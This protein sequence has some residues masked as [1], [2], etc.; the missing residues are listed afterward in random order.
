MLRVQLLLVVCAM[1]S[2]AAW[3]EERRYHDQYGV[4]AARRIHAQEA[5]DNRIT[6][7]MPSSPTDNPYLAGLVITLTDNRT[8]ICGGTLISSRKV[9][10]AGQC[11][12]DGQSQGRV[13]TVVL[14]SSKLFSGG[15]RRVATEIIAHPKFDPF[16]I[17]NDLAMVTI[18]PLSSYSSSIMPAALPDYHVSST[19]A[20]QSAKAVG[21]GKTKDKDILTTGQIQYS[22][23][24]PVIS[25][26]ECRS[27]FNKSID[28]NIVCTSGVN[29]W[30]ACNG[31]GGT[32]LI[33]SLY[34][35]HN[36][37]IGVAS[38]HSV[39]G[40]EAGRPVG[41]MRVSSYLPWIHSLQY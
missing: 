18:Q 8:S 35:S 41:Y 23:F 19:F 12:Y 11:W 16:K 34:P 32:P 25:N 39:L 29:K 38:F 31:D 33:V 17:I 28:N 40:C 15:V 21:Y 3:S 37:L 36:M 27:F 14:G 26:A 2:R 1:L 22:V 4:P 24:V 20:G 9:L 10:T 30:G 7:G 6:G 5:T 13:M